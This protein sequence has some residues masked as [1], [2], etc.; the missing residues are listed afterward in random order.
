M[1][2]RI[3]KHHNQSQKTSI[4][5][6]I[7]DKVSKKK[8]RKTRR[9][10]GFTASFP[11]AYF[12]Y[13]PP[14][15][16]RNLVYEEP[17]I[18]KLLDQIRTISQPIIPPREEL[19]HNRLAHLTNE[20]QIPDAYQNQQNK[21]SNLY[22]EESDHLLK[23]YREMGENSKTLSESKDEKPKILNPHTG[24]MVSDNSRNRKKIRNGF[25]GNI[26]RRSAP[27]PEMPRGTP[28]SEVNR[29]LS[30][31]SMTSTPPIS[32]ISNEA[33]SPPTAPPVAELKGQPTNSLL[34]QI[35]EGGH[36]LKKVEPSAPAPPQPK[37][38]N[39]LLDIIRES[40]KFASLSQQQQTDQNP[41]V[42]DSEWD[43]PPP[44]TR[45]RLQMKKKSALETL[46]SPQGN[47]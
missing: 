45:T 20:A 6:H 21:L 19:R 8:K 10:K 9:K 47:S 40:P 3:H 11:N 2:H 28:P 43:A 38:G 13:P 42:R 32:P 41:L 25:Y 31:P 46:G 22:G 33:P 1:V 27:N 17:A 16:Q 35:R 24:R 30:F 39:R 26:E 15:V 5:I 7:G 12:P 34:A 44:A 37:S 36:Q 29:E 23:R 14:A 18:N 4:R